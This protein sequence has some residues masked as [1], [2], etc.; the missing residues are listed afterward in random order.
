ME[1]VRKTITI[2]LM[3]LLVGGSVPGLMPAAA[4][5][6][7]TQNLVVCPA[8]PPICHTDSIQQAIDLAINGDTIIVLAG[9]YEESL[10]IDKVNLTIESQNGPEATTINPQ[11]ASVGV[12]V[13][14]NLGDVTFKGFNLTGDWTSMGIGQGLLAAEGT[15]FHVLNNI[16]GA[17]AT[18]TTHG[19]AIQVTGDDS[20]VI[21]NAV[22]V[23]N[24][25]NPDW[26][27]SGILVYGASRALIED[28]NVTSSPDDMCIGIG[29]DNFGAPKAEGVMV[30]DNVVHG[31]G[32]GIRVETGVHNT[33]V[34]DNEIRD[35]KFG[36]KS[37]AWSFSNSNPSGTTVKNNDFSNNDVQVHDRWDIGGPDD[38][39]DLDLEAVLA[40][41]TF[42]LEVVVRDNPISV[43]KIFSSIQDGVDAAS[44]GNTVS[45]GPGEYH[46]KLTLD[47]AINITGVERD[48]VIINASAFPDTRGI[49]VNEG[50]TT[51]DGLTLSSFTLVGPGQESSPTGFGVKVFDVENFTLED[52]TVRDFGRTL[53]DIHAVE[54]AVLGD[55]DLDGGNSSGV[56]IGITDSHDVLIQDV[57]TQGNNW[58]AVGIWTSGNFGPGGTS[59][60]HVASGN[61]FN[62]PVEVYTQDEG[63]FGLTDIQLDG[64]AYRVSADLTTTHLFYFGGL[65]KA[66]AL[67]L[68]LEGDVSGAWI[69]VLDDDSFRVF[70]GLTIQ[71]ALDAASAGN[72]VNV[73][74]GDYAEVGHG[75]GQ[76][77]LVIDVED[78]TL[79]S[80]DGAGQTFIDA[81]GAFRGVRV[82]NGLG[83]VTIE[84]FTLNDDWV[85]GGI[86]GGMDTAV[87]IHNNVVMAP[88]S[89]NQHGNGI[90]TFA[91]HGSTIIG[92]EVRVPHQ[93]S[94]DW[95]GSGILIFATNNVTVQGNDVTSSPDDY[96][97]AIAGDLFGFPASEDNVVVDNEVYGCNVGV[98]LQG[99]VNGT[100]VTDNEIHDNK[101]GLV[102]QHIDIPDIGNA[103]PSGTIARGNQIV[104]NEIGAW[105][106]GME[107]LDARENWWGTVFGPEDLGLDVDLTVSG[108][109][110]VI[111]EEVHILDGGGDTSEGDVLYR[112]WCLNSDCSMS[113]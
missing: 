69:Q 7:G 29:G 4:D 94:P 89:T 90:Q 42:D 64:F 99:G 104:A 98:L 50:G 37:I 106:L 109:T 73:G 75:D 8:G 55:L 83:N 15:S 40:D 102:T 100:M 105:N 12:R 49:D 36:F 66:D 107:P 108:T 32:N 87:H 26:S 88:A 111:D 45:V 28:N 101:A 1:K 84:G 91:S 11:G 33:T 103:G 47:K 2:G 68:V 112:P 34:E 61:E 6:V 86:S 110:I 58:G 24:Q 19:N 21:G 38:A 78:L 72:T 10:V 74:P 9:T 20:T 76:G 22:E 80:T 63:D 23:P 81:Q 41:N 13:M 31:C 17:P 71:A 16:V 43:P 48:S 18:T 62:E 52:V 79:R 5:D 35:N 59:G 113:L 95:S 53:V 82:M 96:C 70:E 93:V 56:G 39:P 60:V 44:A 30:K 67:A 57:T 92:N 77:A 85:A 3:L 54:N 25:V 97:V 51:L 65:D 46:E 14:D 27:G